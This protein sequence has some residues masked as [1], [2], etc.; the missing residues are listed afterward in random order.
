M[1]FLVTTFGFSFLTHANKFVPVRATC[2]LLSLL[3]SNRHTDMAMFKTF[4]CIVCLELQKPNNVLAGLQ[5][6]CL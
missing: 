1:W 3:Q 4:D 6:C 5:I 2:D